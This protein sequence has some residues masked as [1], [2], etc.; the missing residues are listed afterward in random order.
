[1]EKC[2]HDKIFE[3]KESH[4]AYFYKKKLVD[5]FINFQKSRNKKVIL[6]LGCGPGAMLEFLSL[7]GKTFGLDYSDHA[8]N[9]AKQDKENIVIKG[10]VNFLPIKP[11][12]VDIVVCSD[13]LSHEMIENEQ[14]ILKGINQILEKESIL[15]I[16]DSAL[17]CLASS[18]DK[19]ARV[20]K[21]FRV[22]DLKNDLKNAGF[23]VEKISYMFF[24]IFPLVFII[25]YFKNLSQLFLKKD[26]ESHDLFRIHPISNWLLKSLVLLE[27]FLLKYL[28][29]PLNTYR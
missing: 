7:Y 1:M 16:T 5:S 18:H 2:L 8:I 4:F 17:P 9:Y 14:K 3:L 6:D 13:I 23:I 26:S 25:R 10:D 11:K 20:T 28:N 15:F 27:V 29:L 12:K 21:R 22:R 24:F 19:V